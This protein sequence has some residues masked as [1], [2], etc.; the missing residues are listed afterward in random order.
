MRN[1][2]CTNPCNQASLDFQ[3]VKEEQWKV[4]AI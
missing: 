4:L 1:I 2:A 3:G